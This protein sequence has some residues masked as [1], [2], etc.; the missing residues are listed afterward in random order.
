LFLSYVL[1]SETFQ[2]FDG[3]EKLSDFEI[4]LKYPDNSTRLHTELADEPA[5]PVQVRTGENRPG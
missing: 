4:D 1:N 2:Q 3:F 5:C